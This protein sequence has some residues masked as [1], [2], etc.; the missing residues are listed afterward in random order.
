[1]RLTPCLSSPRLWLMREETNARLRM[2]EMQMFAQPPDMLCG[3]NAEAAAAAGTTATR[4]ACPVPPTPT[5]A[6]ATSTTTTTTRAATTVGK[7]QLQLLLVGNL[8]FWL[9]VKLSAWPTLE[10]D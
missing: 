1:M 9:K 3:D 10:L 6:T 5:T 2:Q 7:L 4:A 8:P